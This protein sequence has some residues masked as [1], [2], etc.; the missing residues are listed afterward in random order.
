MTKRKS[1]PP[2]RLAKIDYGFGVAE[3]WSRATD[4]ELERTFMLHANQCFGIRKSVCKFHV[5]KVTVAELPEF[6]RQIPNASV[7]L[8]HNGDTILFDSDG[9]KIK[10]EWD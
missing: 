3:F 9:N 8:K 6:W 1:L 2:M 7:L 10:S 5:V 4:A